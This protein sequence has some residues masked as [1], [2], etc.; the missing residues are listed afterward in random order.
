[1]SGGVLHL[2]LSSVISL[3]AFALFCDAVTQTPRPWLRLFISTIFVLLTAALVALSGLL[4][5]ENGKRISITPA[6]GS[7]IESERAANAVGSAA[8]AA[9]SHFNSTACLRSLSSLCM[10]HF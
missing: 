5:R 1:M 10:A 7:G 3:S 2:C 6:A 9:L 4:L 8:D